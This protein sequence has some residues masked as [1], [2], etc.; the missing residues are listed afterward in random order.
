[1]V[2]DIYDQRGNWLGTA[3]GLTEAEAVANAKRQGMADATS[4]ERCEED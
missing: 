2:W 3:E 1:M 4:A